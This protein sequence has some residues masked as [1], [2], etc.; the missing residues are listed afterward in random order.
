MWYCEVVFT[1]GNMVE[2]PFRNEAE[3]N[4]FYDSLDCIEANASFIKCGYQ[5]D[6]LNV[7]NI[8]L[9]KKPKKMNDSWKNKE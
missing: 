9:I 2:V 3:A 4:S 8:E 6:K 5:E 7:K 1:S